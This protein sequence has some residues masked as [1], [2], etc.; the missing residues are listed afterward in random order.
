MI[1][2]ILMSRNIKPDYRYLDEKLSISNADALKNELLEKGTQLNMVEMAND[3]RPF[4]FKNYDT[5]KIEQFIDLIQ[6][7]SF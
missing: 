2:I 4:L 3:V 6:Q 1:V 5:K 7:Y